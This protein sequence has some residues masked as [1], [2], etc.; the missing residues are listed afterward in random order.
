MDGFTIRYTYPRLL[1]WSSVLSLFLSHPHLAY[2][3][4]EPVFFLQIQLST[5]LKTLQG[6]LNRIKN[7]LRIAAAGEPFRT[8]P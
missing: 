2:K 4:T 8:Y 6:L 3:G 7:D 5:L 1:Y